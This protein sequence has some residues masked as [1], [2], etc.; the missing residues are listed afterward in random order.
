VPV[1]KRIDEVIKVGLAK[2][3]KSEGYRKKGRT[4]REASL[5]GMRVVNVQASQW[6][7]GETGQ[8]TINIGVYF[9]EL[10]QMLD[11]KP[12]PEPHEYE[13]MVRQ[14]IG[15]LMDD[16]RDFWWHI[17]EATAVA[18]LA[19]EV[20]D[21]YSNYGQPWLA[22]AAT[23]QGLLATERAALR[24]QAAAAMLLGDRD[25]ARGLLSRAMPPPGSDSEPLRERLR[26]C[27]ERWG[28]G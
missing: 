6:N 21:A 18:G 15:S 2:Q 12:L 17:D 26:R 28:L 22:R 25:R 1:A 23:L 27:V 5:P 16:G 11:E 7:S 9:G 3:L 4:F 19:A 14:R 8:V 20:V 24:Y 13:C 10:A